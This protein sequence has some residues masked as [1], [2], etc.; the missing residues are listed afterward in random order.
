MSIQSS[1]ERRAAYLDNLK[2]EIR[3]PEPTR[4]DG[5]KIFQYPDRITALKAFMEGKGKGPSPVTIGFHIHNPCNENCPECSG[6]RFKIGPNL[7]LPREVADWVIDE[8]SWMGIK[9]IQLSGGG[10]P[11][12]H[13]DFNHIIRSIKKHD[14]ELGLITNGTAIT[15]LDL[16]EIPL[17]ATWVRMSMDAASREM[18]IKSHGADTWGTLIHNCKELVRN[19]E[20]C[21]P[22]PTIGGGFL[23][24]EMTFPDA[25]NFIDICED[26]GF[27]YA[28]FR[29]YQ[30]V[31]GDWYP[32]HLRQPLQDLIVANQDRDIEVVASEWRRDKEKFYRSY[33]YCYGAHFRCEVNA[34]RGVYPCCHLAATKDAA[35]GFVKRKYDFT[36]ILRE[37]DMYGVDVSRCTEHCI[38]HQMNERL[39]KFFQ[40]GIHKEFLG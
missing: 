22:Y 23:V 28:Q 16:F 27:A 39:V 10:E 14:I 25:Q 18:R 15:E 5:D 31:D 8:C 24:S 11:C 33:D 4:W 29:P 7:S 40:P 35:W 30:L 12:L 6:W 9:G 19:A 26:L 13:P 38:Y 2:V 20:G 21:D 32:E 34:D 17:Y 3:K 1:D 37:R 36:N